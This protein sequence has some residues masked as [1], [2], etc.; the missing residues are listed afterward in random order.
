MLHTEKLRG[1]VGRPITVRTNDPTRPTVVLTV[2][3][4]VLASVE[5]F[6]FES[7]H[8]SNRGP[9]LARSILL[10]KKDPTEAGE[11]TISRA[12][13]SVPWLAVQPVRLSAER[14]GATGIPT[15]KPG[16]WVVEVTLVGRPDYGRHAAEIGFSTGLPREPEVRIPVTADLTP[17]VSLSRERIEIPWPAEVEAATATVLVQVRLGLDPSS[18]TA[19]SENAGL[20]VVLERAGPRGFK[21]AARWT[22]SRPPDGA[23]VLRIG[24]ESVRIP[25]AAAAG[26][27]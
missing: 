19:S 20:A 1:A 14:P 3:A 15:G 7:V 13:A 8:L 11:L 6:P 2:R 9:S 27:G 17:P 4:N 23:V 26:P 21:L 25:V 5:I 24:D 12:S 16:D 22:E 10:V 18:L